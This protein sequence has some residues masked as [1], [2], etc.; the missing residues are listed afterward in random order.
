MTDMP[1]L[2]RFW[3]GTHQRERVMIGPGQFFVAGGELVIG[4]ILGSC[5]SACIWDEVAA[6]GGMNHFLLPGISQDAEDEA[7]ELRYGVDAMERLVN[8]I[9]RRG[10][11]RRR[12][13]VKVCGGGD[14]IGG[15]S[16]VGGQNISFIREYLVTEGLRLVG[17][18]I[19]GRF[20]RRVLFFPDSGRVR[21]KRLRIESGGGADRREAEYRRRREKDVK[22][23]AGDVELF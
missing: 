15:T 3:D 2:T 22:T 17:E 23:G 5:I 10:G 9:L 7:R 16:G 14:V 11:V 6:V 8:R 19:G 1:C 13:A 4:T 20:A 21:V 12:L 18:D